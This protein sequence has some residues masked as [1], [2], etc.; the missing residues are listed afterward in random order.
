MKL[1]LDFQSRHSDAFDI[2]HLQAELGAAPV[3]ALGVVANGVASAHPNPL[4]D[5][6]VLALLLS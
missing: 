4:R 5:G 2:L 6:S 1:R 3:A